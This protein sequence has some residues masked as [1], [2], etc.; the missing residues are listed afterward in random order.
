MV[1]DGSYGLRNI[2]GRALHATAKHFPDAKITDTPIWNGSDRP[3]YLDPDDP[4]FAKIAK[5][6]YEEQEKLY[7]KWKYFSGDLFHEGGPLADRFDLKRLAEGIERSMVDYNPEAVW[8]VQ[9]WQENPRNEQ[10]EG[11]SKEHSLFIDLANEYRGSWQREGGYRGREWVWC[12]ISQFGARVGMFGNL[13]LLAKKP[14]A[15]LRS[16]NKGN[17]VGI[18]SVLE[19]SENN[20]IYYDLLLE[21]GWRDESVDVSNWVRDYVRR[22]YGEDIEEAQQ[23]W[24]KFYKTVYTHGS[25]EFLLLAA[26]SVNPQK[27]NA[28]GS[29]G[30]GYDNKEFVEGWKLLLSCSDELGDNA[31]YRY[32]LVTV[33]RQA[34]AVLSRRFHREMINAYRRKDK[35]EFERLSERFLELLEDQDSL[36]RTEE[37]YLLGRWI[38][39]AKSWGDTKDERKWL[40]WMARTQCTIWGDQSRLRDYGNREWAG[41]IRD[42]Y[43][44]RWELFIDQLRKQL[45]GE[46][47]QRID[48]YS[49][50][51][52][53]THERKIYASEPKG[54]AIA[55]CKRMFDKYAKYTLDE[56]FKESEQADLIDIN[57]KEMAQKFEVWGT[58]D[59]E[60]MID[61]YFTG[62]KVVNSGTSGLLDAGIYRYLLGKEGVMV[63]YPNGG[64][65]IVERKMPVRIGADVFLR[66]EVSA[67]SK[68]DWELVVKADGKELLRRMVDDA[69]PFDGFYRVDVPVSEYGG[70]D[71]KFELCNEANGQGYDGALWNTIA[72]VEK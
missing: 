12:T 19:A 13:D 49:W 7:G 59:K 18:G 51:K 25:G 6:Y 31:G 8:V 50:E 4:L 47:T 62:W 20:P 16:D 60:I 55:A 70:R 17:N 38:E 24:Q 43:K 37:K 71:V 34:T 29:I 21:M 54:D 40:E 48:Y 42:F 69:G 46:P 26:P 30:I 68:G 53:W 41:L 44:G 22:R 14:V 11:M 2:L 61:E 45:A 9:A 67:I 1:Y 52:K 35:K 66:I 15:M 23:A 10:I 33:S 63:N 36:L 32:D 72:I 3:D 57:R 65:C 58:R 56:E 28:W 39:A 5:I 64:A 27:V